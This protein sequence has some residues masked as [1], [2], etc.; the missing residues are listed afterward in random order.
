MSDFSALTVVHYKAAL[1]PF[2]MMTSCAT[3]VWSLQSRYSRIVHAIRS[4]VSEGK[5]DGVASSQSVAKQV[6]WLKARSR[7]LRNSIVCLYCAM[8]CFLCCG[9]SI[10][11]LVVTGL[12]AAAAPIAL[13]LLGLSLIGLSLVSALR[14]ISQSYGSLA[15]EVARR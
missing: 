5:R 12:D 4:L 2:L 8:S 1:A 14:E 7:L 6:A 15:E 10:A 13:F 9:M 11:A 3:L